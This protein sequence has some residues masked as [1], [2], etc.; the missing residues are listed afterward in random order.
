MKN[1]LCAFI[2]LISTQKAVSMETSAPHYSKE[3][4]EYVNINSSKGPAKMGFLETLS[5]I[6][7][8]FLEKS[9]RSPKNKMPEMKP[10]LE[11]FLIP[12]ENLKFVWFGHS[13]LMFN[14]DGKT[15]L[16]DPV[17]SDY[18]FSIDIL[19]KRFQPPVLKLE[20]LPPVDLIVI[21]HD[22]YDHLDKKTIEFFKDK[23]ARF[24]VPKG[25]GDILIDW[26]VPKDRFQ[27]LDWHESVIESGIK[28]I[29]TPAQHF[30]GRGLFDRNKTLWASWVIQGKHD[31]I[32]YSGDSGY[33]S[34]FKE[35]G[36]KYG[37]FDITF[38]EN[39]QYNER[40]A[41]IHM[42]PEETLQAHLDLNGDIMVPVHWGMFDLSL[43]HWTEPV[44]RTYK[45]ATNWH[46][47]YL[48]PRLGE[49]IDM[50][51]KYVTIPWW[52]E[53]DKKI[54]EVAKEELPMK[55]IPVPK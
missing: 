17:F 11:E 23:K 8:V 54:P 45:I 4:E 30:S 9:S 19:V 35:I 5:I 47:P 24:L 20:E 51:K 40:W 55:V 48:G 21:S 33:G 7:K 6:K 52:Q 43:H 49:V 34:H 29:A 18:A 2:T 42:L 26:D 3:K 13:T 28:F 46:I 53:V 22:H 50:S 39:G 27:E 15:I 38:L 25:V 1:I 31:K 41:D 32:Y 14:L 12:S 16:I 44:E 37:P 36:D 10:N